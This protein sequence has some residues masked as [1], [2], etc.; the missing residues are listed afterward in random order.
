MRNYIVTLQD[1]KALKSAE[2]PLMYRRAYIAYAKCFNA[3]CSRVSDKF[4]HFGKNV[5]YSY[6][7]QAFAVQPRKLR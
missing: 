6:R 3:Q 4:A 2:N 1:T 7:G 5:R